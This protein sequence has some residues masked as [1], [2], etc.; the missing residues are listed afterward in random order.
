MGWVVRAGEANPKHLELAYDQH[1]QVPTVWGLSVQYD[2]NA[3]VDELAR[4][5]QF[6][7]GGQP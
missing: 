7:T 2:Q 1:K 3:G 6:P 4:A 5:G